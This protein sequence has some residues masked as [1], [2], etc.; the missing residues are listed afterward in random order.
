MELFC[1]NTEHRDEGGMTELIRLDIK[2]YLQTGAGST[3]LPLT[4]SRI[5]PGSCS[6]R[7]LEAP[8]SD[9]HVEVHP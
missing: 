1:G 4:P 2:Q 3:V 5:P 9:F 6:H 8:E 7:L